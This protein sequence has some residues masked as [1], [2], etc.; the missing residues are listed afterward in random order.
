MDQSKLT[1][2]WHKNLT[3]VVILLCIWGLVSYVL[4]IIFVKPLNAISIG[5]FPLGFWFANQGSE[6]IFVILIFVYVGLMSRLD[7]KYD[8]QE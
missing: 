4:G 2:Y 8:V 1:E 3:Y 5:G 7:R 6:V